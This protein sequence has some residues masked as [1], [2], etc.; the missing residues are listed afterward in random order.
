VIVSSG[1]GAKDHHL[2]GHL[3]WVPRYRR[4][5]PEGHTTHRL[6]ARHAELLAGEPVWASSPQGRFEAGAALMSGS[7]L[8]SAQAYG[9]HLFHHY[10]IGLALH[11]HLGLYGKFADGAM[12]A[13]PPVGELRMRLRNDRHWIDLRG[14]TACELLEPPQVDALLARLGADP[15]RADAD[16][17]RLSSG[18]AAAPPRSWCC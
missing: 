8:E 2:S 7:K 15:L 3:I 5:M 17:A 4:F 12:P 1:A 16:P 6:A 11:V 9:K 13:P 18:S 14:P 10:D